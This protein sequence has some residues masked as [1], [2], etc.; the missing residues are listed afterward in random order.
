MMN[1]VLA[2]G[3]NLHRFITEFMSL[4]RL[5]FIPISYPNDPEPILTEMRHFVNNSM[6]SL[7]ILKL[8]IS[9]LTVTLPENV[10]T[11]PANMRAWRSMFEKLYPETFLDIQGISDG[12]YGSD[13]ED[14]NNDFWSDF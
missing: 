10:K 3:G 7:I 13:E 8:S 2:G 6:G 9:C 4:R 1:T 11:N 14:D 5:T 12:E